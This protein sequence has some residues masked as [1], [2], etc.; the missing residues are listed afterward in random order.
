MGASEH[1]CEHTSTYVS[2]FSTPLQTAA[3]ELPCWPRGMYT[4]WSTPGR[5]D[6]GKI[7]TQAQEMESELSG[8]RTQGWNEVVKKRS[9]HNW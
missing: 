4:V 6:L 8:Q 7:A 9:A 2:L 1:M 5:M 3:S